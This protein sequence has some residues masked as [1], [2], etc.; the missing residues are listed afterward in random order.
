MVKI[1]AL[2]AA[3]LSMICLFACDSAPENR[4]KDQ[5]G[6]SHRR[7]DDQSVHL[8]LVKSG[9][10]SELG[11]EGTFSVD[12]RCL[13]L[14]QIDA[15]RRRTLPIFAVEGVSWCARDARLLIGDI[16]V[17][18][19]QRVS[20]SGSIPGS[21]TLHWVQRP[22]PSCDASNTFLINSVSVAPERPRS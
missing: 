17:A 8:P 18:P 3:L 21:G 19:G 12:G 13:Y 20:L 5:A 15:A 10:F 1:A 14:V 6:D 9:G 7:D 11:M 4:M 16:S 2:G 22:H